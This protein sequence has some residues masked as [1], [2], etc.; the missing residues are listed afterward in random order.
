MTGLSVVIGVRYKIQRVVVV[1]IPP[2]ERP[3]AFLCGIQASLFI[4][5]VT[6]A[7]YICE[8]PWVVDRYQRHLNNVGEGVVVSELCEVLAIV[9]RRI[10]EC[11]RIWIGQERVP[12]DLFPFSGSPKDVWFS[13]LDNKA[14]EGEGSEAFVGAKVA[15]MEWEEGDGIDIRADPRF[16]RVESAFLVF[17]F[18]WWSWDKVW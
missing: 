16:P 12:V 5:E 17:V 1:F 18:S 13:V 4:F 8:Y 6:I 2:T 15:G 14:D 9:N 7:V 10:H 11:H 3:Q